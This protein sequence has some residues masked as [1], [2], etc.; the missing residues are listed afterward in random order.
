MESR[1]GYGAAG[2][3]ND[4]LSLPRYDEKSDDD[5]SSSPHTFQPPVVV[6]YT[7]VWRLRV[8][9]VSFAVHLQTFTVLR[10]VDRTYCRPS[11]PVTHRRRRQ[12]EQTRRHKR[13]PL[14]TATHTQRQAK[15][16]MTW[17]VRARTQRGSR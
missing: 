4:G 12:Q 2:L 3:D 5:V 14:Q 15:T 11:T 1:G 16:L 9:R 6:V 17:Y 10:R 7:E 8:N 13:L